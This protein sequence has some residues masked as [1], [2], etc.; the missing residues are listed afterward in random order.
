M[1][2]HVL[3]CMHAC[4]VFC[5]LGHLASFQGSQVW[6]GQPRCLLQSPRRGFRGSRSG[7][8]LMSGGED[9][10]VQTWLF[11]ALLGHPF[12]GPLIRF[13]THH[14]GSPAGPT[15]APILSPVPRT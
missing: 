10:G 3:V 4:M 14:P 11:Q 6:T 12:P 8:G 2:S 5:Q 15:L 13:C 7:A 1:C 9:V